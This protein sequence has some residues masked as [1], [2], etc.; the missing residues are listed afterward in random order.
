MTFGQIFIEISI[1]LL[2]AFL[3]FKAASSIS[4]YWRYLTV[5]KK[6][7]RSQSRD[8]ISNTSRETRL[9]LEFL[10]NNFTKEE[11]SILY[12]LIIKK[13]ENPPIKIYEMYEKIYGVIRVRMSV[14]D[15]T[16]IE[17]NIKKYYYEYLYDPNQYPFENKAIKVAYKKLTNIEKYKQTAKLDPLFI[18]VITL[19]GLFK[20]VEK[21]KKKVIENIRTEYNKELAN[22]QK[23]IFDSYLVTYP[24][25]AEEITRLTSTK[26]TK[27]GNYYDNICRKYYKKYPKTFTEANNYL[28]SFYTDYNKSL[29]KL[30]KRL[31]KEYDKKQKEIKLQA[32][33]KVKKLKKEE[34][35]NQLSKD[36]GVEVA[37]YITKNPLTSEEVG[38]RYEQYIGYLYEEE[39]FEVIY[40]GATQG[41]KDGGRDLIVTINKTTLIVQCKN[42]RVS[43]EIHENAV[44]QLNTVYQKYARKHSEEEV[45][46]R[47]ITTHDN[48]DEEARDSLEMFAI[49]HK[50]IPMSYN[51]PMIKC[52]INKATGKKI[53]HLPTDG[54][55][56]RIKIRKRQ[57][58]F[59]SWSPSEAEQY[60]FTR[61][62]L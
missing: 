22:R 60:G 11:Q 16:L 48:L 19:S 38:L 25:L 62:L 9:L 45:S 26:F 47:L 34:E 40:N 55:Y 23:H 17:E 51:Y 28:E 61:T 43:N 56:N 21:H 1:F 27:Y 52:N 54:Q 49:R 2:F 8:N 12:N 44:N 7:Y 41:K 5:G 58:N 32:E 37:K 18:I 6:Y 50:V 20:E 15:I 53:Y 31:Q 30:V 24:E 13:V 42:I 39:G 14:L 46:P 35:F 33:K 3:V 4:N 10:H 57:G 36:V 59:Y 29:L